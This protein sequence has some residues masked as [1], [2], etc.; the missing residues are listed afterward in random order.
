MALILS[1]QTVPELLVRV[2]SLVKEAYDS[3]NKAG[4]QYLIWW[5]WYRVDRGDIT[6][7]QA[8]DAF[9]IVFSRSLNA[10]QFNTLVTNRLV[11]IKDRYLAMI[12]EG[13]L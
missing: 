11:P 3:G 9:N 7:A 2:W 6:T 12:A 8:R 13:A 1:H 4:Y 5:L 10:S